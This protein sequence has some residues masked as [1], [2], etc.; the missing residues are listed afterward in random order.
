MICARGKGKPKTLKLA[1]GDAAR[2]FT[3]RRAA[4]KSMNAWLPLVLRWR[5]RRATRRDIR[6][7]GRRSSAPQTFFAQNH[8][9]FV[10]HA[11]GSDQ[12]TSSKRISPAVTIYRERVTLARSRTNNL[13]IQNG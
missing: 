10:T 13:T 7:A 5:Q 8:F 12:R 6:A 1:A 3:L 9:H 2:R 11:S 4:K